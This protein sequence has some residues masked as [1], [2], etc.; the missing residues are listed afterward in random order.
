MMQTWSD[1]NRARMI[2]G[3]ANRTLNIPNTNKTEE[4]T[5][6]AYNISIHQDKRYLNT[7]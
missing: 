7:S 3:Q 1:W 6:R 5:N 4:D 2:L